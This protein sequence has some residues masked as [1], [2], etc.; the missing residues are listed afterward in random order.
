MP[1]V[2]LTIF[3]N[4]KIDNEERYLRMKDSFISFKDISAEKWVINIRGSYKSD[5]FDFLK[6]HL[7]E[8][9]YHYDLQSSNG[10]FHDTRVML[11]DINSDYIFFWIEDHINM[12]DVTIYDNIL[13]DMCENK[14][15][16]FIYSWWQKSGLNKYEYINKKETNNINIYNISD[17][18]IRIIEKRI[19]TYFMPIS[20][21]SISTNMFFKKIVTS[22]HP[23]LKR[24]PRETPFDF[25]KR[26]S[27]FEFFPF[28]LSFPKFELFANIDDNHGTVGY[29]LIDRGLY[30]NRMTRDEIKSI[31]FRKSFNYYRL[32]K[33]IFPNVIW[34]LLVSIFV[35]I[36][37][38][39]YTYG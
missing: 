22:N 25:E 17:R 4:F 7:G 37:R 29:S 36:K 18:N 12:V 26:S 30:E 11:K 28:V 5:T 15:D 3:A 32:I 27:D 31:E 10:W 2:S 13:K 21:V 24:W 34:K 14:V 23:K 19:G 39:V 1:N 33:T 6:E 8:K 35:Y 9:L 38:L 20:A 16:H